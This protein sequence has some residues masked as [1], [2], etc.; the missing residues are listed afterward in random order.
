MSILVY[1]APE[2]MDAGNVVGI[3]N[4]FKCPCIFLVWDGAP[5]M[6]DSISFTAERRPPFD[7][8]SSEQFIT[9]K[10]AVKICMTERR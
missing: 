2:D 6:V 3:A 10:R 5:L 8:G 9:Y 1:A 7:I 4:Y